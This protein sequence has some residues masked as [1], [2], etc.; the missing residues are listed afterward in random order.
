MTAKF[1]AVPVE[2]DGEMGRSYFTGC[3]HL[4]KA[5]LS[6]GGYRAMLAARPKSHV[7]VPRELLERL[8]SQSLPVNGGDEYLRDTRES[9]IALRELRALLEEQTR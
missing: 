4:E 6:W 7:A 3:S 8:F 9:R 5:A 1:V 2:P